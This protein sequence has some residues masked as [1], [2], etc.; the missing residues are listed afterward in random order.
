MIR[1][2]SPVTRPL[3]PRRREGEP[4]EGDHFYVTQQFDDPDYYWSNAPNPP[5]PLPTH[6][7]TDIGNAQCGYP[8]V[9][10]ASGTAYRIKDNATALGAPNDA[11][12]IR[13]DHGEGVATAYWHLASW[14]VPDGTKV[15]AGQEIGK[16]G[17]TGLGQVC[18][19]HIEATVNGKRIDPEPLMFEGTIPA[20]E[21]DVLADK[22]NYLEQPFPARTGKGGAVRTD[23][24]FGA[25]TLAFYTDAPYEFVVIGQLQGPEYPAGSGQRT[26]WV[27]GI[28]KVG[29][30][31]IHRSICER[32]A[33]TSTATDNKIAAALT[34]AK[35]AQQAF[36]AAGRALDATVNV[37]EG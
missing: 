21:D 26:W 22:I 11:L 36:G 37:L 24:T 4:R 32:I 7:A 25:A 35:G 10:M 33:V 34:A 1:F 27:F 15:R 20:Q 17:N 31:C 19:C 12:G 28:D 9:A 2:G 18:H 29:L 13:I 16:L 14:S 8:I 6:R 30:R 3:H 23:A 5:N